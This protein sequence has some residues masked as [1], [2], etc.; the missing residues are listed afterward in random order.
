MQDIGQPPKFD[1]KSEPF[2]AALRDLRRIIR[3]E[4]LK[5]LTRF[6][7]SP[8]FPEV[9]RDYMGGLD[10]K[11]FEQ[12]LSQ[13]LEAERAKVERGDESSLPFVFRAMSEIVSEIDSPEL[14][15]FNSQQEHEDFFPQIY[16]LISSPDYSP[17][18]E[19]K[20]IFT[21]LACLFV[22]WDLF[23]R[24]PELHED[25]SPFLDMIL[26][27]SFSKLMGASYDLLA[28]YTMQGKRELTRTK[29]SKRTQKNKAQKKREYIVHIFPH[30]KKKVTGS[31][32]NLSTMAEAIQKDWEGF[33]PPD[34]DITKPPGITF[35]KE[36]LLNYE[37]TKR[38][39]D[40]VGGLWIL[41]M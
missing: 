8:A 1:P 15:Q 22:S 18:T 17:P 24:Y 4:I 38:E 25:F 41:K 3:D 5:L 29:K 34:K 26:L 6:F 33:P 30:V 40:K 2:K 39:F 7:Y 37:K 23:S 36:T 32:T 31:R 20:D 11:A 14:Q 16:H 13:G 10:Y 12:K 19:W 35:I 27:L 9:Y 21:H 28:K